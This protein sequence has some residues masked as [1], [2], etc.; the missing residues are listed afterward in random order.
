VQLGLHHM[1]PPTGVGA[2]TEPVA[3]L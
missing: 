2:V 1:G 3:C